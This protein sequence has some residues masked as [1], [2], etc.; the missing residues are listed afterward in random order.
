MD[1]KP[2]LFV[3]IARGVL[4]RWGV[5][6]PKGDLTGTTPYLDAKKMLE[7]LEDSGYEIMLENTGKIHLVVDNEQEKE[8]KV[9]LVTGGKGPSDPNDW[10]K[11]LELGSIFLIQNKYDTN[12]FNLGQCK[13]VSRTDK[14]TVLAFL[15]P[16]SPEPLVGPI[17]PYRFCK[18]YRLFETLGIV[19]EPEDIS[20]EDTDTSGITSG[21]EDTS[22]L[23]SSNNLLVSK[24]T[25]DT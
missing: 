5:K 10:L 1:I 2:P 7:V 16:S 20:E 9:Q 4:E 11:D 14:S 25:K 22:V 8:H 6:S 18:K 15:L 19:R 13:L 3:L 23:P 12:D 21:I 24:E 17:D